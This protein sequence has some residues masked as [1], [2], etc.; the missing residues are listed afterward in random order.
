MSSSNGE[1]E[2][3]DYSS[4]RSEGEATS[5]N[6]EIQ[7]TDNEANEVATEVPLPARLVCS[8]PEVA[9]HHSIPKDV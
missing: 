9:F 4:E 2:Y 8:Q 7:E 1:Q 3:F 5:A 6:E